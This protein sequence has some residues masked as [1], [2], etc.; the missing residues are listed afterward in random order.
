MNER[1]YKFYRSTKELIKSCEGV[2]LDGI[3]EDLIE[4]MTHANN[5]FEKTSPE[6]LERYLKEKGNIPVLVKWEKVIID[7]DV[8]YLNYLDLG[9]CTM[10]RVA[11]FKT[12]T[13]R[14]GMFVAVEDKGSFFFA[15]NKALHKDY[16]REKLFLQGDHAQMAD[17]LNA[18]LGFDDF[19]QQGHYYENIIKSIEPCG[20]GGEAWCMPWHPVLRM[21]E[22]E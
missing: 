12:Y 9:N 22:S 14:H 4:T 15:M 10:F 3:T 11:I 7:Y 1:V 16:V 21:A 2:E 6:Y 19:G 8:P 18:Q 20:K 5:R 17:F 13:P